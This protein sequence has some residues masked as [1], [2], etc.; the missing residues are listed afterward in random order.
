MESECYWHV[1]AYTGHLGHC[2]MVVNHS[3]SVLVFE[4]A[5]PEGGT[6]QART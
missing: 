3:Y 4:H 5:L 6:Y 1:L 2:L